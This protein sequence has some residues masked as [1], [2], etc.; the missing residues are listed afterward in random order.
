MSR[1]LIVLFFSVALFSCTKTPVDAGGVTGPLS[2]RIIQDTAYG[3]DPKQK[4]DIFL[5][6]G[7]TSATKVVVFIHGGGWEGGNKSDGEY[8]QM[9]NLIKQKW[10]Q[11]AVASINYRLTSNPA[12]HYQE[13]MSDVSSAVNFLVKNKNSFVTSD[14]LC[15]MGTSAGAHLAMLYTYKYNADNHVKSVA[16]FFGPSKLNDWEW[17]NSYNFWVGKAVKDVIIQFNGAPWNDPLYDSNSPLSVATAQT[18]PTI[19]FHG[20]LDVIVPIYQSQWLR[21]RLI[22]LGVKNE[23]YEY[24]DGHGFNYFN[25]ADAID[26]SINF[27]KQHLR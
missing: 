8:V 1:H 16:N 25:A 27:F 22:S 15:M 11:A 21:A 24:I 2:E 18:K 3:T 5:P 17:Y 7:R 13:I 10:P 14:T 23:Y 26:K 20:T 4:L 12:I 9:F 6:A 19:I